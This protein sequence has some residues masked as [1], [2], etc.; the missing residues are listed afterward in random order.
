MSE[1]H[2]TQT[3]S[4]TFPVFCVLGLLFVS[5]K[6]LHFVEWHWHVVLLPFYFA[7]S[8]IAVLIILIFLASA[9]RAIG[10]HHK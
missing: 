8:M 9:L 7:F 5:L 6:L 2:T 3:I 1:A 10:N 4:F